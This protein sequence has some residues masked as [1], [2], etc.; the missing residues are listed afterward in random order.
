MSSWLS[1]A[2]FEVNVMT[3]IMEKAE[4]N[5]LEGKIFLESKMVRLT[6]ILVGMDFSAASE[7]ALDYALALA[8]RYEARIYL[9]NVITSDSDV[10]LA[11]ELITLGHEREV[12]EAQEK[13]G[14]ILISGRLRGVAHETV[15]EHGSL[16]PTIEVLIGKHQI[17]LV[18]VG[19]E[20]VGGLQ[21][22]LLGSGAEQIFRQA[23]CPVLTVGPAVTGGAPK[24]IEF[25][26]IVFATDFGIGAEREAEYA[27]SFAREHQANVTLLHVVAHA[28]DYSEE[29][30]ALKAHA[31]TRELAE[32]V[33]IGGEVWCKPEFRMRLG[34][35]VEEI[36]CVAREMRADLVVIG[37]KRGK[38]LAAGHT[39]NTIAYKV[40]CGAPCPVL[41]VRS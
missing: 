26:N 32:L 19:T 21:K 24:E 17:D 30:L 41:T 31:I 33:P 14:E 6:N 36:L 11:P 1:A 13:M 38:G 39:P 15:I 5:V 37:A 3:K 27:F 4:E 9:V 28:D 35:P 29:G 2:V 18:V 12:R 16:W 34:D 7:R 10:M 22:M 20:G 40:V 25:K 8:R 23:K